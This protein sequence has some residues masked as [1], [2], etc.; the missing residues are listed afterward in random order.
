ML[1]HEGFAETASIFPSFL[2]SEEVS[3]L[4]S[5]HFGIQDLIIEDNLM[6][7]PTILQKCVTKTKPRLVQLAEELDEAG[8]AKTDKKKKGKASSSL[9]MTQNELMKHLEDQKVLE[10]IV[11][12][13]QRN[14]FF[15]HLLPLVS[16]EFEKVQEELQKRKQNAST[17][18]VADLNTKIEHLGLAVLLANSTISQLFEKNKDYDT[19]AAEAMHWDIT[20]ALVERILLLNLKRFKLHI[21]PSLMAAK[22]ADESSPSSRSRPGRVRQADQSAVR[23]R[24]QV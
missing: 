24:S 2:S 4:I 23:R 1:E 22:S 16:K 3:Q 19:S 5:D 14:A 12:E 6:I 10:Y 15:K 17:D 7:M 18:I 20:R 11:D 9:P 8:P 13:D 21:D